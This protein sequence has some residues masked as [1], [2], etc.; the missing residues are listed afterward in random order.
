MNNFPVDMATGKAITSL[1]GR[2]YSKI[3]NLSQYFSEFVLNKYRIKVEINYLIFLSNYKVIS[4]LTKKDIALMNHLIEGYN[5]Q[6]FIRIK[7]IENK[8]NH[9]I[10]AIEY[11]LREKL[12]KCGLKRS[13]SFIHFGLT[14]E[15]INNL[16]YG[17]ILKNFKEKVLEK[18]IFQLIKRLKK[19]AEEYQDIPMLARTHGQPAVGTTVGK[20][21][22]NYLYRLSKQF[23]KIKSFKFEG[24]CNGAV[25]NINALKVALPSK[26]WIEIN[27][28]F[29]ESFGLKPNLY[30]TQILF[31]DN[32]IEF[33]QIIFLINAILID[34]SINIWHYLML[35]IF[36]QKKKNSEVGSSTMPQKVNPINFEQAEGA[37]GLAN[38]M[39]EFFERKLTHSRL[40]RDL[41]DSIIR[42]SFSEAFGYTIL[43]YKNIQADLDKLTVNR[44]MLFK[45]LD[46]HWEILTEAVQTVLRL[47]NDPLAYER[48]KSFS[49]GKKMTK[50][51]YFRLLK[52]LGLE[53]NKKLKTLKPKKYLG[54][55]KELTKLLVKY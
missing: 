42:R 51:E 31:Y 35:N 26:N 36:S 6:D 7:E 14:S 32:W 44:E 54:Y 25:G 1:D 48:V 2:Y 28:K 4:K 8:T 41:S 3:S 18:E 50:E 29:V 45:E 40:Q 20:E 38:S 53:N 24:K 11:F 15:D 39:L 49:R 47:K 33:F 34:L 5:N 21:L 27:K 46:E 17:I 9:D 22:A 37:L 13:V 12:E 43:G 55:A 30:T 19:M 23:I 52:N 16:A 10:K